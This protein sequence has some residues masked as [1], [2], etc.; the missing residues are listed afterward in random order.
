MDEQGS[1][2]GNKKQRH[3]LW[4]AF[5]TKRKQVIAHVFGP[6]RM[7]P[8]ENCLT[9]WRLLIF[10]SSPPITGEVMPEKW[11]QKSLW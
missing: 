3:W 8:A 1:F 10:V 6:E 4:Y 11:C 7:Q 9:Y 5:D 2:V